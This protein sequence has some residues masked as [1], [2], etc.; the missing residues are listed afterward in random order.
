MSVRRA[1]D[2]RRNNSAAILRLLLN[3]GPLAR[4]D[5]ASKLGLSTGAVTRIT[6]EM[7]DHGLLT[8]LEPIA[9]SDA[10]R[11]PVP[12]DLNADAF[13]VAGVH[14][15]LE[16]VTSGL[17]NLR[18]DMIGEPHVTEHGRLDARDAITA[19][20]AASDALA[21]NLGAN[22]TLL[23]TGVI[24]GGFATKDWRVMAEDAAFGWEGE[25]VTALA[26]TLG[27]QHCVIDNA[28]RAHSRAE[29]LFGA[30]RTANN[31]IE[32]FIGNL[33][34]AAVVIDGSFYS[35]AGRA[36]HIAHL[37]IAME[38]EV[39]CWCGRVGCLSSVAGREAT[40]AMARRQ[41]LDASSLGDIA[42]AGRSGNV[43]AQEVLSRRIEA[44]GEAV[45][46]LM[47][48]YDPEIVVLTGSI[49]TFGDHVAQIRSVVRSR[50]NTGV[51]KRKVVVPTSLGD[52]AVANVVAAA[53][54]RLAEVYLDP[55]DAAELRVRDGAPA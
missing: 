22:T 2:L 24:S 28:Y 47:D 36:P 32:F 41:G 43:V 21:R 11:R 48:L 51:D 23:G 3:E 38:S 40:V 45:A 19:A 18:G 37:P 50:I 8:E 53:T 55:L 29:M 10:G 15:G 39:D 16:F 6:A 7:A 35:G 1:I 52:S 25:D 12:V 13:A 44:I 46:I 27:P 49:R 42:R 30:A 4:V 33:I 14:I 34:G 54:A 26:A 17:V 20:R 5:V 31:F 9:S